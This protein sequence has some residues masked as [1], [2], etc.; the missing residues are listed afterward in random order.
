MEEPKLMPH[1]DKP[2]NGDTFVQEEFLRLRD[3]YGIETVVETGTALGGT[4]KWLSE[5]YKQVHT[6]EINQRYQDFARER[7]GSADNVKFWLGDSSTVLH[8]VMKNV[9]KDKPI[10]FFLDAH[11]GQHN[12]LLL[13]LSSIA[14]NGVTA[15]IAI[16]DAQ[17]PNE[18]NLGY[19]THNDKPIGLNM[20]SD[21]LKYVNKGF[22]EWHYNSDEKSTEVKRGVM[23]IEP[24]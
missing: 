14:N 1:Q 16:H 12:P 4:T 15:V 21:E 5:N 20:I 9:E 7:V 8:D 6:I 19:D 24:V 23:Y 17:V 13:E 22:T 11:W 3:K 18:P 10:M 2:F